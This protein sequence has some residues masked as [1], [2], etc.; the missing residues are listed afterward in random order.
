MI[1]RL[2]VTMALSV[3]HGIFKLTLPRMLRVQSQIEN[4]GNFIVACIRQ[5]PKAI[6]GAPFNTFG[7]ESKLINV[8]LCLC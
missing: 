5:F 1:T 6:L 3:F 7:N 4:I 8:R 2:A